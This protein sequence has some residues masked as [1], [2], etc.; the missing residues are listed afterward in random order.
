[1]TNFVLVG[2]KMTVGLIAGS[3]AIV[4]DAVNNLSDALSSIIT[5]VGVRLASRPADKKHPLGHGRIEYISAMLV[6]G[7]VVAVGLRSLWDSVWSIADPQQPSYSVLTIGV[8]AVSVVV[9]LWLGRYT[10]QRGRETDSQS[11]IASGADAV[12]DAV[13]SLGTLVSVVVMMLFDLNI[14]GWIALI[15]SAVIIKAGIEMLTDV[16]GNVL[17]MRVSS[18]L[19]RAIK[20]DVAAFP[21]V[22][23]AYDLFLDSYGPTQMV[24][25]VHVELDETISL[26]DADLQMRRIAEAI[27]NKYGILLTVGLYAIPAADSADRA[28]YDRVRNAVLSCPGVLGVHGLRIDSER[29]VVYF[30]AVRDFRYAASPEWFETINAAVHDVVPGYTI[31][32]N[33]DVDYSD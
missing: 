1:M 14:D 3:M 15:I 31:R 13:I 27:H 33:P 16:M 5:I 24:G 32:F 4:L 9:K 30:D 18:Q 26:S 25:A 11:L 10:K 28:E 7:L 8:V 23:G 29:S 2:G 6:A 22:L 12:F 17:G 19:S 21:H 20:A